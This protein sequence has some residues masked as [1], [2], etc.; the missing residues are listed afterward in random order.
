MLEEEF[1]AFGLLNSSFF[2]VVVGL[3]APCVNIVRAHTYINK[4]FGN[5]WLGVRKRLA[6]CPEMPDLQSWN[7]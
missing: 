5:G 1:T 3:S 6:Y 7:T 2:F 4:L